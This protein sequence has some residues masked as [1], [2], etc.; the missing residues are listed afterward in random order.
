MPQAQY[1]YYRTLF[2][3]VRT[4]G[5]AANL[6]PGVRRAVG[7]V[8]SR[9][10]L[11]SVTTMRERLGE[12]VLERRIAMAALGGFAAV[13]LLLAAIGLYGILAYSVVQR[14]REIGIRLALGSSEGK[15]RRSVLGRGMVLGAVGVGVGLVG[16]MI[17]S[18]AMEALLFG[19][20]PIDP[21]TLAVTAGVLLAITAAASYL[22]ARRAT[23]VDPV[24]ALRE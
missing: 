14:T 22:P 17:V 7:R 10:P 16:W 18:R 21:L 23:R 20:A 24:V 15:I 2:L 12:S 9:V 11:F 19:V 8:D 4:D 1:P 13:A 3:T 6:L 5:D